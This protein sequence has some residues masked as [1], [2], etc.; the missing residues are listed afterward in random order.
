MDEG[1][2][3]GWGER[4]GRIFMYRLCCW[5][6]RWMPELR[7]ALFPELVEVFIEAWAELELFA[8]DY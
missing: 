1:C 7:R 2:S 8:A 4:T 3:R 5:L 6:L